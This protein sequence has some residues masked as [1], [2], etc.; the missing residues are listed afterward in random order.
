[1]IIIF[2]R[3]IQKKNKFILLGGFILLV[4]LALIFPIKYIPFSE[5]NGLV[6]DSKGNPIPNAKVEIGFGC[7][8]PRGFVDSGSYSLGSDRT[9][10]NFN[11]EFSFQSLSKI[12]I[13]RL[14]NCKKI[15]SAFKEG[16]CKDIELCTREIINENNGI[17]KEQMSSFSDED[18][19]YFLYC[20]EKYYE[21]IYFDKSVTINPKTKE[22]SI[23]L[24]K[25]DLW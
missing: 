15:I 21:A 7:T 14:S 25:F 6:V 4:I 13:R 11:G 19:F 18:M 8:Q 10:T 1:M 17:T 22:T 3:N 23:T 20:N 12:E 16:Y 24:N 5:T 2:N 9:T